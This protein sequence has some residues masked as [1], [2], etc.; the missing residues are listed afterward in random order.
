MPA[1]AVR[2]GRVT[3]ADRS[4]EDRWVAQHAEIADPR[5]PVEGEQ[6]CSIPEPD[7]QAGPAT[8]PQKLR[9]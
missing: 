2:E 3:F 9:K 6:N 1:R 8:G 7:D 5:P 4:I